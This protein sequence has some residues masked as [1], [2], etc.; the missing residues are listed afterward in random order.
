[1]T[2][3]RYVYQITKTHNE[4]RSPL[5]VARQ[6]HLPPLRGSACLLRRGAPLCRCRT[7]LRLWILTSVVLSQSPNV[8]IQARGASMMLRVCHGCSQ[9]APNRKA[10]LTGGGAMHAR[11]V[12]VLQIVLAL[13]LASGVG[14][15]PDILMTDLGTLG[16]D[17]SHATAINKLSQVAGW[18]GTVSTRSRAFIWTAAGG[19]VDLGS[20]GGRETRVAAVNNLGQVVGSS[21]TASG[22]G[23]AFS[24]TAA[25]GMVDLGTL[26]G[27]SSSATAVNNLGQ[28]VGS[29]DTASG[30]QHAFS[31]T[32][33]GGMVDL[34]TLGGDWSHAAAVNDL[35]Q[36][37]GAS[38]NI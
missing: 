26:G 18:S 28:V 38:H 6:P 23:H 9:A 19:M 1:M 7:A 8:E 11:K 25:G 36:V 16:G 27:T 33:A 10:G 2:L 22:A 13:L 30:E 35:G 17:Y 3:G 32:A 5:P 12:V 29:S 24:W 15:A 4:S 14:S 20:L 37:V 34:G 21:D 31:W